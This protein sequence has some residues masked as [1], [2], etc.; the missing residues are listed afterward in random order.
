MA[1]PYGWAVSDPA[2]GHV[3][4][5]SPLFFLTELNGEVQWDALRS[6]PIRSF[7]WSCQA[8]TP[9]IVL[10][11]FSKLFLWRIS[12]SSSRVAKKDF[13]YPLYVRPYHLSLYRIPSLLQTTYCL[14]TEVL[15][16]ISCWSAN[17]GTFM[18][19]VH[20]RTSL[21]ISSLLLQPCPTCFVRLI[22]MVFKM[23]VSGHTTIVAW[24]LLPGFV[25]YLS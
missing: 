1:T 18:W 20:R 4:C 6:D 22:W 9:F 5:N 7:R 12:Q 19:R 13:C 14:C 21:I 16:E 10:T 2:T 23:G 15:L 3:T 11:V 24:V 17:T 8:L 25:R